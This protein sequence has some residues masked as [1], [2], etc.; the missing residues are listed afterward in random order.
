MASLS[1]FCDEYYNIPLI[2]KVQKPCLGGLWCFHFHWSTA[3]I[4]KAAFTREQV[5]FFFVL[6]LVDSETK[7]KKNDVDIQAVP[8]RWPPL[9]QS[10][11]VE[12]GVYEA[13]V[14]PVTIV[15]T[16]FLKIEIDAIL[17]RQL[18]SP[19]QDA[20]S[21]LWDLASEWASCNHVRRWTGHA[22]YKTLHVERVLH[23]NITNLK[24]A[25][26][27]QNLELVPDYEQRVEVLKEPNSLKRIPRSR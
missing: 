14:V 13:A 23:N 19:M 18:N 11:V 22:S 3:V 12:D 20:I 1:M 4:L 6:S 25:I 17:E 15:T 16:R 27:D 8:P 9:A 24:S 5:K 21:Q 7:E 10:L 26:S 2:F